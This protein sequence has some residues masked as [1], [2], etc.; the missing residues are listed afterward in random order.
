VAAGSVRKDGEVYTVVNDVPV[1]DIPDWLVDWLVKDLSKYRS[2][3]A[4]ERYDRAVAV[5]AIP[6][7]E[8]AAR[9]KEGDESAFDISESDIYEFL[10]WRAF[11]FAAMG[12]EGKTLEKVLIQQVEQFCAGGKRFVES[13]GGKRQIRKAATNKRLKFGNASFFNRMDPKKKAALGGRL[14]L[15]A[16]PPTRMRLMVAAMRRFPDKVTAENGYRRLQRALTGTGF[17]VNSRTKAGQKAVREARKA[18]GFHAEQTTSGWMWA[19][20]EAITTITI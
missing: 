1:L 15:P 19:R 7:E 18:A 5:A 20:H 17:A 16:Q 8:K 10:N 13:D 3:C 4:K 9:Q 12:T 6:D 14:I 2:A 11:H